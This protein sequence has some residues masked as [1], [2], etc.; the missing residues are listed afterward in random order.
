M[1]NKN[2]KTPTRF[3]EEMPAGNKRDYD[4]G[5]I[6]NVVRNEIDIKPATNPAKPLSTDNLNTEFAKQA[7]NNM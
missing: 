6:E 7:Q 5:T 2:E 4:H 3:P 1:E